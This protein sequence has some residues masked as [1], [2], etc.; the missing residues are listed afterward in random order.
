M[1]LKLLKVKVFYHFKVSVGLVAV[2]YFLKRK[3][4]YGAT[5]DLSHTPRVR[6]Q[7]KLRD[8]VRVIS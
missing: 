6:R 8:D 4:T 7:Q 3:D 2:N 1:L 5:N